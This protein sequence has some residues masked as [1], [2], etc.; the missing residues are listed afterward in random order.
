MNLPS[1]NWC[2]GELQASCCTTTPCSVPHNWA[3]FQKPRTGNNYICLVSIY[4]VPPAINSNWRD[5]LK[6]KLRNTLDAGRNYCISFYYNA[7]NYLKYATNRFGAYLDDGSISS[8][9]ACNS[10]PIIPQVENNPSIFMTDTANWVKIEGNFIALGNENTITLGNFVDSATVQFQLFNGSGSKGPF[11]N[12]DDV[13]LIPVDLVPCAGRDTTIK[14]GDSTYIGRPSEVGL[15]DDCFWHTLG[16]S[17]PFDTVAGLWIKPNTLGIHSYVV[18][19]NI[20]G[21]V[22]YDTVNVTVIPNS[23]ESFG[24]RSNFI[25]YPNPNSGNFSITTSQ[26]SRDMLMEISNS[27]GEVVQ[28]KYVSDKTTFVSG[29]DEG[30]YF[31]KVIEDGKLLSIRKVIVVK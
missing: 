21:T 15:D 18:E 11:Y 25:I 20:C 14:L 30:M 29:L 6:G 4:D 12:I 10:I 7:T 19:Q 24:D 26:H 28:R 17:T 13:S 22:T 31:V 16:A 3:G 9:N 8:Y 1:G 5:Y 23:I 2:K 27:L